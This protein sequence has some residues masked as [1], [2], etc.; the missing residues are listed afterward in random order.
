MQH[1]MEQLID[2]HLAMP[3]LMHSNTLLASMESFRNL[4][5]EQVVDEKGVAKID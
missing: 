3:E 5:Q 2:L 1:Q 4:T